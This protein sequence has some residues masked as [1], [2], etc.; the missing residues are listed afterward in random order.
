MTDESHPLPDRRERALKIL[1]TALKAIEDLG[2]NTWLGAYRKDT[3]PDDE[4]VRIGPDHL[5]H[6]FLVEAR[7]AIPELIAFSCSSLVEAVD[8]VR[9]SYGLL[10]LDASAAFAA[11][12]VAPTTCA[13][14]GASEGTP[15]M[16]WVK[17]QGPLGGD[18]VMFCPVHSIQE[19]CGHFGHSP[20]KDDPTICTACLADLPPGLPRERVCDTF[21]CTNTF[22]PKDNP[23]QHSHCDIHMNI[24]F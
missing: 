11:T 23:A 12:P 18:F 13:L 7:A 10:Q 15:D 16:G 21:D 5:D 4:L 3:E 2:F 14:C 6:V 8:A 22:T 24:P 9:L 20:K 17:S 19:R 1:E